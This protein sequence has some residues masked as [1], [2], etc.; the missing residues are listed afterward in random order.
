MKQ[1]MSLLSLLSP[2]S[3]PSQFLG[4]CESRKQTDEEIRSEATKVT[5]STEITTSVLKPETAINSLAPNQ[6]QQGTKCS[7][8]GTR[9]LSLA[10][11]EAYNWL[12]K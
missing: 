12:E 3:V 10:P 9:C 1:T 7:A 11:Q 6:D 2:R 5:E 8:N 4:R